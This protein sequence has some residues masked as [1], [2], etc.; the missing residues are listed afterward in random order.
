MLN[1]DENDTSN[2]FSTLASYIILEGDYGSKELNSISYDMVRVPYDIEKEIE[3]LE[4]CDI[5]NKAVLIRGIKNAIPNT[6]I[7][8]S[9]E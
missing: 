8:T 3:Y 4:N 7:I 2:K 5:P 1:T 9:K 6:N